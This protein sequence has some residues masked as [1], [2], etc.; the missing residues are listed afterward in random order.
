[1]DLCRTTSNGV[2]CMDR[3]V[4]VDLYVDRYANSFLVYCHLRYS[5]YGNLVKSC[6]LESTRALVYLESYV[7]GKRKRFFKECMQNVL[8]IQVHSIDYIAYRTRF[9]IQ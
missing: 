8:S 1:M 7:E 4:Y 3:S 6:K 9:M 5:V 2:N